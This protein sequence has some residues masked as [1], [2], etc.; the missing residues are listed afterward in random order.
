MVAAM[1]VGAPAALTQT[2]RPPVFRAATESVQI[3][4]VVTDRQGQPVHGLTAADFVVLDRRRAQ[5]ISTFEEVRHAP[6]PA[7]DPERVLPP[8][9]KDAVASN[10]T[11]QAER[12]V[13]VLLDDLHGYRGRDSV[14]KAVATKVVNDLGPRSTMALITTSGDHNVEVTEDRAR[15]LEGISQYKGFRA[16]RR[17]MP[18]VDNRRGADLGEFD[19][20]M[21]LI[22]AL[23]NAARLLGVNDG[24]RKAF[25]LVSESFAKDLSGLFQ[26]V[27]SPTSGL[28]ATDTYMQMALA[29]GETPD[30]VQPLAEAHHDNALLQMMEAMR[31]ANVATYSI[32][33]R[34]NIPPESLLQECQPSTGWDDDP[35][36]GGGPGQTADWHSWIRMAQHGLES[37]SGASGGFAIVN[38]DDFTGGIDRILTDLDNYYLIGFTTDDLQTKGYRRLDVQVRGRAD[39]ELRYRRGYE[40]GGEKAKEPKASPLFAL[41]ES[42]LPKNA[43]P[44][45]L[46]APVLPGSG[47]NAR[48]PV[49]FEITVPLKGLQEA[50][51][52]VL[53][54][55]QYAVV[56]VDMKGAK[57][58]EAVGRGA[59]LVLRPRDPSKPPPDSVTYQIGHTI[60]LPPG[61]YQLRAS[62]LSAKIGNGGSVY[63]SIDVPD[64]TRGAIAVSDLVIGHVASTV[65]ALPAAPRGRGMGPGRAGG[66]GRGAT[67][68]RGPAGGRG[69]EPDLADLP[70]PPSLDRE[71]DRSDQLAVYFEV[72]RGGRARDVDVSFIVMDRL[73]R[74]V[75][76]F[77]QTLPAANPG[78]VTIGVPLADLGAGAFR[79]RLT[80]TDGAATASSD[81]GIVVK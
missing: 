24:R 19:A 12:L 53:D 48:I 61:H 21:Q 47:K 3:D 74:E 39:L 17:P 81:A 25:V 78:K 46:T 18:A 51:L 55:I 42:A 23:R 16:M 22:N 67:A 13:V 33:P 71:F 59:R 62:V 58:K 50:D 5:E 38:T 60:S 29:G 76:R 52:R 56:A 79:L 7:P 1:F 40:V 36:L 54:D 27:S 10:R 68:G 8:G 26:G 2:Q 43:V 70:F 64:F 66:G 9:V 31:R 37:I 49:T 6:T 45:R 77:T 30:T 11:A 80:A 63:L 14:V 75:R 34:G 35:C 69:S 72:I 65:A 4:V 41:T 32:D 20:N 73:D 28:P 44:L 57:V 15:M